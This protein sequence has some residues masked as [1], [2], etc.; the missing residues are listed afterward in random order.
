MTK[1]DKTKLLRIKHGLFPAISRGLY[2]GARYIRDVSTQLAPVDEGD[3][4]SSGRVEPDHEG[5]D[6]YR[7]IFGGIPGPH[8]FVDY[9]AY[10]EKGTSN[11]NYPAQPYLRPAAKAIDVK[12]EVIDEIRKL[13][14]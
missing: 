6:T 12:K 14:Q 4:R 3:L 7:I 8:K 2:R 11:P 1:L 13:I 5:D 9:A 10:V